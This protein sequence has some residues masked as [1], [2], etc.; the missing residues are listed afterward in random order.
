MLKKEQGINLTL[1][2]DFATLYVVLNDGDAFSPWIIQRR[3]ALCEHIKRSE[4][5][6]ILKGSTEMHM[7]KKTFRLKNKYGLHARPAALLVKTTGKFKSDIKISKDNMVAN[8]KSIMGLMTL[9]AEV[10]SEIEVSVEGEDQQEAMKAIEELI[11]K[12]FHED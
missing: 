8:G 2:S 12:N 3:A 10:G 6:F 11:E 5:P 4:F 7:I 9:V 1:I